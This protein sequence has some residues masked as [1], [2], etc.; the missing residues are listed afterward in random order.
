MIK[1]DS[2]LSGALFTRAVI[3]VLL[4]ASVVLTGCPNN[5]NGGGRP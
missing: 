4:A 5:N 3:G 1:S 2:K